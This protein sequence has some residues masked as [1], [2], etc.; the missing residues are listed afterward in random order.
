MKVL[1]VGNGGREHALAWRIAFTRG[2]KI[3]ITKG[4]FGTDEIATPINIEPSDVRSVVAFAKQENIDLVVVGP[5]APLAKG[6]ADELE[7]L[8][9]KFF[10]PKKGGALIEASKAFA[11]EIMEQANVPCARW[12]VFDD[13]DKALRGLER[14]GLP[15]VVKADG[16]A[17]GKGVVVA[18]DLE[19]ARDAIKKIMVEKVFGT[20]GDRV[21]IEEFLEGKEASFMVMTDGETI[22]PLA[23]ARDYKR[24]LDGDEGS[25][26]G[27]MGAYSPAIT[28]TKPV[29]EVI[30]QKIVAPTINALRSRGVIYRGVLYA[31]LMITKEGPKVLEF[32]CRFGDPE[33]QPV[34]ARL[35]GDFLEALVACSEGRL[36][37]VRLSFDERPTVCVVLSAKGY[38]HKP[39]VG[40]VIQGVEE[41]A[42]LPN[43]VVFHAG[44][45]RGQDGMPIVAGGRVLGVTAIGND[46]ADARDRAYKACQKI[47]WSTMHYRKDIALEACTRSGGS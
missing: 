17:G 15:V 28:I 2:T 20:S 16:L 42:R 21:V 9:I 8:G 6:L 41:A 4:N 19:E 14:F 38:P 25:N 34:L 10:G 40:E 22:V 47:H 37:E 39:E 7:T 1:V 13:A 26:T 18:K 11:H 36:G 43:I 3:F 5:E 46:F 12:E 23:P 30:L 24:L 29:E 32:N 33:T 45:A 31:G 27:G 35:R 44:T